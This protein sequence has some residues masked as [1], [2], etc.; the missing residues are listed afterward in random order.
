MKN[1][2]LTVQNKRRRLSGARRCWSGSARRR[3]CGHAD[4]VVIVPSRASNDLFYS[5]SCA[6]RSKSRG[7][8]LVVL[9][10]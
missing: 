8:F 2:H 1:Q 9:V 10:I 3:S 7:V 4:S 6:F 5:V